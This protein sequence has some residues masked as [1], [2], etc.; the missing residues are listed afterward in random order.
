LTHHS[1]DGIKHHSKILI[2]IVAFFIL[3][4]DLKSQKATSCILDPKNFSILE[5]IKHTYIFYYFSFYFPKYLIFCILH[6]TET[7]RT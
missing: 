4:F 7:K 3:N 5:V 1:V 6:F 2:K